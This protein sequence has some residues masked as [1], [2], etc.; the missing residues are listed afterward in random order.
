MP[1]RSGTGHGRKKN[2]A[3]LRM[4]SADRRETETDH[5]HNHR[6]GRRNHGPRSIRHTPL[7]STQLPKEHTRQRMGQRVSAPTSSPFMLRS[8]IGLGS[9]P[10][11]PSFTWS[12]RQLEPAAGACIN[13]WLG[14]GSGRQE[15]SGQ[16]TLGATAFEEV[17]TRVGSAAAASTDELVYG[18]EQE[19]VAASIPLNQIDAR[20]VHLV[21]TLLRRLVVFMK[22]ERQKNP[23]GVGVRTLLESLPPR[24]RLACPTRVPRAGACARAVQQ[25]GS[26]VRASRTLP[27]CPKRRVVRIQMDSSCNPRAP[28]GAKCRRARSGRSPQKKPGDSNRLK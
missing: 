19:A 4:T 8:P 26:L 11:P 20:L 14:F 21:V 27:C 25:K 16:Q 23:A 22:L 2:R 9:S 6:G 7:Q 10:S 24:W 3:T 28:L 12:N 1:H 17:N 15:R 13:T 5:R 18:F